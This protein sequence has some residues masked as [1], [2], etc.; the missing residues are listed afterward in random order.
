MSRAGALTLAAG[1]LAGCSAVGPDYSRPAL[2]LPTEWRMGPAEAGQ[3]SNAA[4]WD[5]FRDPALSKLVAETIAGSLD[6]KGAVARVDQARA[7]YG[8][9]RSALFP[10]V[11]AD[12]S[13][14]RLHTSRTTSQG[15]LIPPGHRNTNAYDLDLSASY[16]ID[17]WGRLRRATEAAH[18]QL[19]ASEEGRRTVVLT[20]VTTVADAYIQLLALDDELA[21]AQ[22]TLESRREVLRLQKARFDGGVAPESDMRQAE[23]QYQIAAAAVP[24]LQRQVAQQENLISLLAGRNPGPVERGR[25]FSQLAVP[26]I[27]AGLPSDLLARRPDI[28]QAEQ[29]LIA[30]NADIGVARAAYFPRI[31]LTAL[32]GLQSQELAQ[33]FKGASFAWTAGGGLTQSLFSGGALQS[34]VEFAQARQRELVANYQTAVISA[35]RDVNDA[36]IA[37]TTLEA[38]RAEQEK[39]VAALTRLLELAKRRYKEGAAIFLEVATAEQSLFDAQI[40]LDSVRAQLFQS[41]A[42]LYR[43][44]GGGW[45]QTA[46]ALAPQAADSAR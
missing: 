14:E 11:N 40:Q 37:R 13:G 36:L 4:W 43:A 7:Q 10:Q 31:S 18:A 26:S 1:V 20:L 44:F 22:R 16:E 39:N 8:L 38:Q 30:A 35:L 33:L 24:S 34:Q 46:E 15:A 27:P 6:L 25:T 21:I 45:V 9:A 19:L 32:L 29:S 42:D 5:A 17:V 23:A 41:Y 12:A 28:R 2:D 3:I